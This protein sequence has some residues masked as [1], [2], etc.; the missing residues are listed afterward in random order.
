MDLLSVY[1]LRAL[2]EQS[3]APCLSIFIPT[4]RAGAETRQAPIRFKNLLGQAEER[5]RALGLRSPQVRELLELA[6]KLLT[7]SAFWRHQSDGLAVFAADKL[8][9]FYRLPLDFAELVVVG[10]RCH[11]KPLLP[12]FM[13]DGHFFILALSQNQI[14]LLEGTRHSV[15][16]IDLEGIPASLVEALGHTDL[17]KQ[18]QFH[19]QTQAPGT[20]GRA[21]VFHSHHPANEAKDRVLRYFRQVNEGLVQALRDERAPLVLAGVDYL[22]PLYKEA[23]TY[24]HLLEQGITGSPEALTPAEL[25][26]RAWEIVQPCF[27]EAKQVVRA[28]YQELAGTGR[29]STNIK[30]I[31]LAACHGRVEVLFVA[32]GIQQWGRFVPETN[33]VHLSAEPTPGDEDLSD[34]AAIQTVFNGGTV[35]AV[36]PEK[37]PD[38]AP[39]A[40]IF[41]Y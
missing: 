34:L 27:L 32:V 18:L 3:V 1:E 13:G 41:R 23:N 25:H 10:E 4:H 9:R 37:V 39:L 31:V 22:L 2:V 28:Q 6:E 21:A 15:D 7:D 17:E 30:E 29:T 11:V 40:A 8:F 24:P 26:E 19:T 20:G 33:T 38:G 16:E 12:L 14:R 35:Y 5:L 36:E